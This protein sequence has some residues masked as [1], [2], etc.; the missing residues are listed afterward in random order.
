MKQLLSDNNLQPSVTNYK[1]FRSSALTPDRVV[2]NLGIQTLLTVVCGKTV[3][4][5]HAETITHL[6]TLV[7]SALWLKGWAAWGRGLALLVQ[8]FGDYCAN[9]S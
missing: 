2:C 5:I 1:K 9:S 6:Q 4:H 3:P 8:C 7:N